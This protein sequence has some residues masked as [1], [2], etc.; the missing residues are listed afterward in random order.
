M[1]LYKVTK[2]DVEYYVHKLNKTVRRYY[3]F[4]EGNKR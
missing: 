4:R 1:N 2:I 3:I